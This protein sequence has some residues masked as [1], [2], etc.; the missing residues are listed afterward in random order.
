MFE[1]KVATIERLTYEAHDVIA[2]T[3]PTKSGEITILDRHIPL[4]SL[5]VPGVIRVEH[6]DGREEHLA[7]QGGLVEVRTGEGKTET[8]VLADT[9]E[10]SHEIDIER[11]K[12]AK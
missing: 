2:L 4:I 12:E 11:A 3:L 6:K 9:A 1:L 7:I 8:I 10:L 5:L